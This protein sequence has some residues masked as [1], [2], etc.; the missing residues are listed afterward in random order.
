M[1]AKK[2]FSLFI[3]LFGEALII[4]GFIHFGKNLQSEILTLNIVVSSIIYCL[5]FVDFIFPW[6]NL[7]DKAQKQIG[8]I[9]LRWFFTYLY[10]AL[11][12]AAMVIFN[13]MK[14]IHF[15]N[16][17]LIHGILF[18]VVLLGLFLAFSS[19][20]KVREVYFEEKQNRDRTDEMKKATKELQLKLD[21]MNNIPPEIISRINELQEN[22]RYLSPSNNNEALVLESKFVEEVNKL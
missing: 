11:A 14:P 21:A 13:T 22:L 2:I 9:G 12:I 1:N 5:V 16:Q 8:S 15:I 19:S 10:I 20:D 17:I 3:A 4:F 6:A 18:F 7:K